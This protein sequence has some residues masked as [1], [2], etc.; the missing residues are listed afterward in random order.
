[1]INASLSNIGI[2]EMVEPG[3]RRKVFEP[4]QAM[5]MMEVHFEAGSKSSE[6]SHPY[7]QMSYCMKG[8][9]EIAINGQMHELS[10]GKALVIPA[11]VPHSIK[12]LAPGILLDSYT[13]AR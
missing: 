1:M 6:H 2:W 5:M 3:I 13:P 10:A 9:F 8:R 12:A 11:G 4:G 7:E